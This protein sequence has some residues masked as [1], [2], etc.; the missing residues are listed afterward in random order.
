MGWTLS[1]VLAM[2][3]FEV[4]LWLTFLYPDP[5]PTEAYRAPGLAP[6]AAEDLIAHSTTML[7]SMCD[8]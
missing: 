8:P 5:D 7:E 3:A 2:P 1:T 4:E 6:V